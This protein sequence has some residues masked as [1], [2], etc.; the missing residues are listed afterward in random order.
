MF[1]LVVSFLAALF[2]GQPAQSEDLPQPAH[3]EIAHLPQAVQ[4][5]IVAWRERLRTAK[6]LKVVCETEETW[7]DMYR[8][9][10]TGSPIVVVRERY[11]IHSWMTPDLLWMVIFPYAG[12]T[13]DTSTPHYQLLWRKS[14]GTVWE[15]VWDP[16]AQVY[17]ANRYKAPGEFGAENGSLY[18]RGC[19]Y[20]TVMQSWLSGGVDLADYPPAREIALFRNP[21]I[22]VVPPDPAAPGLWLDVFQGE[23]TR[24]RE[25]DPAE[26]Y[27]RND[28]MLLA[29]DDKEQPELREWR[30]IALADRQHGGAEAQEITAKRSLSYQFFDRVPET[31]RLATEAFEK[32]VDIII[33]DTP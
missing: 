1:M 20:A 6:C 18:S 7:R 5:E 9:D 13:A 23:L 16:N 19:I 15:R 4:D 10:G 25:S 31:L 22:A 21:N 11:Q 17:R 8:L 28:F 14:A 29:C 27:R 2:F 32:S 24:D 26:L 3:A 12:E 30:T 33:D